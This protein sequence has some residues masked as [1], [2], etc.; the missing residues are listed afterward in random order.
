MFKIGNFNNFIKFNNIIK[1]TF[2][3][4]NYDHIGY[5]YID[6]FLPDYMSTVLPKMLYAKGVQ[7]SGYK[8]K[9]I[10]LT[11]HKDKN[12]DDLADSFDIS[13]RTTINPFCFL[14]AL[15]QSLYWLLFYGGKDKIYDISIA[16]IR[17]G[18]YLA[19]YIIRLTD[20]IYNVNELKLKYIKLILAFSW[21]IRTVSNMFKKE[22]PNIYLMQEFD[23]V[24]GPMAR[25]AEQYGATVINCD[26][27]SRV[28]FLGEK[29]GVGMNVARQFSFQIK[30]YLESHKEIDY[31]KAADEYFNKRR[32][33]L[34]DEAAELAYA[35]K[36]I[37]TRE[38]WC[39]ETGANIEKKNIVLMAHCFSDAANS[40]TDRSIYKNYYEW[41]IKTLE[42]IHGIDNVNWLLKAHPSRG[43][44]NEGDGI[45]N[46]FEKYC[47]RDNIFI[48]SDEISNNALFEI[49]DGAITVLGTCGLEFSI[50]GIPVICAGFAAY[51]GY[52][53]TKEPITEDEYIEMLSN[54]NTISKLSNEQIDIAKRISYAYFSMHNSI[55][56]DEEAMNSAYENPDNSDANDK[57]IEFFLNKL[58]DGYSLKETWHYNKGLAYQTEE[59]KFAR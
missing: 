35:N 6:A 53:F 51:G 20:N 4:K 55:D 58:D 9:I 50:M 41:L 3:S 39:K 44:Y 28:V 45:Y 19:D 23:Y 10:A 32:K 31:V 12:L 43:F 25:I 52:G 17:V 57:L 16:G 46:I 13:T 11:M 2:A 21:Q 14:F 37:L 22:R 38:E 40:S 48:V 29:Y 47:D 56:D 15:F 36:R 1:E 42:I 8:Y 27:H 34:A 59:N 7:A 49:V 18:G 5:I 30:N 24:Y 54:M 26:S 33:G